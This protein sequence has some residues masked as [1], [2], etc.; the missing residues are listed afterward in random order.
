MYSIDSAARSA[1][2]RFDKERDT[3]TV[4]E[5]MRKAIDKLKAENDRLRRGIGTE[6][7]KIGD[8]EKRLTAER[9]KNEKLQE[10]V[11]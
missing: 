7:G 9:K 1:G 2:S 3:E 8:A 6:G 5:T 4:V 11:I 10:E